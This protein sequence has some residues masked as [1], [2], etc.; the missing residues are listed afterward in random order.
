MATSSLK[1][2]T[3]GLRG[4]VVALNG[5][6]AFACTRA[7]AEMIKED[8]SA[9]ASKNMVLVG[10]DLRESSPSIAQLCCAALQVGQT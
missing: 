4:L 1:F 5:V 10:R 8:G 6:P 3:S 7:F 9:A 2:G